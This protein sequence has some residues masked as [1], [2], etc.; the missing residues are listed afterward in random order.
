MLRG[1]QPDWGGRPGGPP[2]DDDDNDDDDEH[3]KMIDLNTAIISSLKCVLKA[4]ISNMALYVN[5]Q[6]NRT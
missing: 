6:L 2:S 3:L 4:S 1:G 5:K